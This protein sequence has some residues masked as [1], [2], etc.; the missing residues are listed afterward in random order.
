M[1]VRVLVWKSHGDIR[2]YALTEAVKDDVLACLSQEGFAIDRERKYSWK[3]VRY[4]MLEAE[5]CDSNMFEYGT[6]IVDVRGS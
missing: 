6:D 1:K 2:V 4:L 5:E 3:Q